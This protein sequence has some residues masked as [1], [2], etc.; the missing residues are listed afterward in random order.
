MINLD[1]LDGATLKY[2]K[3]PY[4]IEAYKIFYGEYPSFDDADLEHKKIQLMMTIL[5]EY[6]IHDLK[7][8]N[9]SPMRFDYD[10]YLKIP[11]SNILAMKYECLKDKIKNVSNLE[12]KFEQLCKEQPL[13][14]RARKD[15]MLI[16]YTIKQELKRQEIDEPIEFLSQIA[17]VLCFRKYEILSCT[18]SIT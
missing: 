6:N 7:K 9:L 5:T 16:S 1:D 3:I 4:I 2:Q 15:I 8:L 11:Y 17:N 13:S 10:E 12:C 14:E 18:D